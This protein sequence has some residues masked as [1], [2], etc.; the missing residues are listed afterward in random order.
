M[1][2]SKT[3]ASEK[4]KRIKEEKPT[5]HH[6]IANS[7]FSVLERLGVRSN[8]Q[9]F[10]VDETGKEFIFHL[11]LSDGWVYKHYR[12]Q[13]KPTKCINFNDWKKLPRVDV[14][15]IEKQK[16]TRLQN[17]S[18]QMIKTLKRERDDEAFLFC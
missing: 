16:K 9:G 13:F 18:K 11:C 10:H 5:V 2:I 3:D 15:E 6:S 8:T 17:K 7:D 14:Q 1:R 4:R 12:F